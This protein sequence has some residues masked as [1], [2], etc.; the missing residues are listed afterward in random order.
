M[1]EPI[2]GSS[3][4]SNPFFTSHRFGES[5]TKMNRQKPFHCC[6]DYDY[7]AQILQRG[8]KQQEALKTQRNCCFTQTIRLFVTQPPSGALSPMLCLCL[9]IHCGRNM[10]GR[11]FNFIDGSFLLCIYDLP[12]PICTSTRHRL[13]YGTS[14]GVKSLTRQPLDGFEVALPLME[15]Q[16]SLGS[17]IH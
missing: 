13:V 10:R 14:N 7:R 12:L 3:T 2:I 1:C 8:L 17:S 11:A 15:L 4:A 6:L 16:V 9:R 5:A